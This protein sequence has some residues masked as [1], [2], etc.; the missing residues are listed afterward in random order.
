MPRFEE[1]THEAC[2]RCV[3]NAAAVVVAAARKLPRACAG[4]HRP[5]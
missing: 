3:S 4:A 2:H 5:R 1:E